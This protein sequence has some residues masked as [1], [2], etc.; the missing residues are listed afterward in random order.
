MQ[1]IVKGLDALQW[2]NERSDNMFDD[3]RKQVD[4]SEGFAAESEDDFDSISTYRYSGRHFLGMT[5]AQRFIIAF[6]LFFMVLITSAFCLFVTEK[7]I[8]PGFY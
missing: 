2:L 8:P 5:P 7:I 3:L 1:D 4:D 6:M